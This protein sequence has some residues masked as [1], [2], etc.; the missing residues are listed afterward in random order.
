MS[1]DDMPKIHEREIVIDKAENEFMLFFSELSEK[2]NL[3]SGE[4]LKMLSSYMLRL[5]NYIIKHE[6]HC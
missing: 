3:T 5:S 1:I 4:L 2:H 6:R